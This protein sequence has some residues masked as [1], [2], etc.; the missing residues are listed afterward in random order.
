M[1]VVVAD[2][3]QLQPV[4]AATSQRV[5]YKWCKW[6]EVDKVEL[7]TI[8]RSNDPEHLLFLNRIRSSQPDRRTLVEYF[9]G[10][11]WYRDGS[12]D[13]C[14]ARGMKMAEDIGKPFS[15]LTSTNAG[16]AEICEAALR[17]LKVTEEEQAQGF[18]C[19][20]TCASDLKIV[21]K[22]GI[23]IRLTRNLDKQRGFV[24]GALAV[25]WE[26]LDGNRCF[27]ARP[28]SS[29]KRKLNTCASFLSGTGRKN[30]CLCIICIDV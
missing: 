8:Y 12:L 26:I 5:C 30:M 13:V 4:A 19:D 16:A 23:L 2:F 11:H 1:L 6:R 10:R 20:Y 15:W 18:P 17:L 25:V 21:A 7:D 22:K 29:G 14:V 28:C 27:V 9:E 24:N 3:Q